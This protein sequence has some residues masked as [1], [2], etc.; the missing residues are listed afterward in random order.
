MRDYLLRLFTHEEWANRSLLEGLH[1]R[2]GIPLRVY[3]LIPHLL[4]AHR[5]WHLR[6]TGGEVTG[7]GWWPPF[8]HDE[9]LR[10]NAE[11]ATVWSQ[12]LSA[13]PELI[14]EQ[15]VTFPSAKGEPVTF[16][17]VDILTQLHAHSVHHRGQIAMLM[18]TAGLDVINTDFIVYC[19]KHP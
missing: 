10:L 18:H 1:G 12:Y 5:F 19:R 8:V 4:Q 6:L 14:E 16:R 17:V 3:E 13:M 11:V 7:F 9:C 2:A 15:R